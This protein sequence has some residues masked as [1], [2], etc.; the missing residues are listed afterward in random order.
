MIIR[1][2]GCG[3]RCQI[4]PYA[5]RRLSDQDAARFERHLFECSDCLLELEF[6]RLLTRGLRIMALMEAGAYTTEGTITC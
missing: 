5:R 1:G 2:Q 6:T 4:E 3:Q